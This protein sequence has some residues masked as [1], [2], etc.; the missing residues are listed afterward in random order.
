M[1][2]ANED[3][4]DTD[5]MEQGQRLAQEVKNYINQACQDVHISKISFI[6]HSLGGL[7]VRAALPYLAEYSPKFFTY[8]TLSSPHLGYMS[9]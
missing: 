5:I 4:T 8:I 2:Q 7:I 3:K 1:S 9:S 6:G